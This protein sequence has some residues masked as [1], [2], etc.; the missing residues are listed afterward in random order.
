M[1]VRSW[2]SSSTAALDC[3]GGWAKGS[4][5]LGR[6]VWNAAEGTTTA[7]RTREA[8]RDDMVKGGGGEDVKEREGREEYT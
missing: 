1:R 8:I 7:S 2:F 4:E 3:L 6:K 5:I